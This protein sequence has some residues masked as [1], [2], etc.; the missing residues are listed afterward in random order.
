MIKKTLVGVCSLILLSSCA[1]TQVFTSPR[2][3]G[4]QDVPVIL[5]RGLRLID[6]TANQIDWTRVSFGVS[7]MP[8]TLSLF[9]SVAAVANF[10]CYMSFTVVVPG[11]GPVAPNDVADVVFAP[12]VAGAN[13]SPWPTTFDDMPHGH[14]SITRAAIGGASN[15]QAGNYAADAM[16]NKVLGGTAAVHDGTAV[17]CH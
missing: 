7:G 17:G 2:Q 6:G 10:P 13:A 4:A 15:T 11:P 5:Y 3:P 8:P 16:H 14:W 1:S 12:A 9:D